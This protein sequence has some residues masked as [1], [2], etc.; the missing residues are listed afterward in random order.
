[1]A[2]V[3]REVLRAAQVPSMSNGLAAGGSGVAVVA[4]AAGQLRAAQVGRESAGMLHDVPPLLKP[5]ALRR[6][7]SGT[8]CNQVTPFT[9][10]NTFDLTLLQRFAYVLGNEGRLAGS[11]DANVVLCAGNM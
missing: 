10:S 11:F 6:N 3:H 9:F 7:A 5:P 1:M 8:A 2:L 4:V